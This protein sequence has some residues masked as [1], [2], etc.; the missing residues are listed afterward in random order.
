MRFNIQTDPKWAKEIMTKNK[1]VWVDYLW[2][3]GC[4]VTCIANILQEIMEKKFTPKDLNDIIIKL[5][6]YR[7]LDNSKTPESQASFLLTEKLFKH[8]KSTVKYVRKLTVN[9]YNNNDFFIAKIH[10]PSGGYHYIN[11]IDRRGKFFLCFDVEYGSLRYVNEDA[12][13]SLSKIIKL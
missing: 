8:F 1:N 9:N 2:R 5:K 11:V 3:W 4:M 6:A 12:I 7:Y 13:I 10:H